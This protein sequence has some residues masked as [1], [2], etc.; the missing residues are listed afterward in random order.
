M[1]CKFL[2][3][4]NQRS[5]RWWI[6]EVDDVLYLKVNDLRGKISAGDFCEELCKDIMDIKMGEQK[7]GREEVVFL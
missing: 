5:D 3:I 7:K 4:S 1:A 6:K 2:S